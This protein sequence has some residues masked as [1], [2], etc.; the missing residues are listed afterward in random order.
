MSFGAAIQGCDGLRL[1]E[2]EKRLFAASR[3]FGFILFDRNLDSPDQIRALT[4][5]MREA[6]GFD[7]PVFIDQEGGRVQRLRPPLARDWLPPLDE[8]A[9]FGP[10]AA[11]AMFLRYQIIALE[12]RSLGIDANCAPTLDIARPETHAVLRNRCYGDNVA[13]VAEIGLAVADG[14]M[15][16]GVYPVMKHMPGHG[17]AQMDT[18]LELPLIDQPEARLWAE[19]F[20]AFRPFAHLPMGMTAHLVFSA[21]DDEPSTISPRMIGLIRDEIGFGGLLMTDDIGM[22]ALSGT[23]PERGAA[24]LAAGCDVVLDCNATL[25]ERTAMMDRIGHMSDAAQ[26]RAEAVLAA[27]PTPEEVDIAALE[28]EFEALL[29]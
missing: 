3:P 9:R 29:T 7:A 20:A 10:K 8:V 17:L 1:S 6:V 21:L 11:R 27:R 4:S 2:D 19:D 22:E 25:P 13:R 16:G 15:A 24:S 12:L 5:E 18:H 28:A 23:R 26:S 14:M